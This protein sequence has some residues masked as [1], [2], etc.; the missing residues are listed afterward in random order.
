MHSNYDVSVKSPT[1][2]FQFSIERTD[3]KPDVMLNGLGY[4]LLTSQQEDFKTI[5]LFL[6]QIKLPSNPTEE[7]LKLALKNLPAISDVNINP[8]SKKIHEMGVS[9]LMANTVQNSAV[10]ISPDKSSACQV[11]VTQAES[12]EAV[13]EQVNTAQNSASDA[14]N[15][16]KASV[17]N[18]LLPPIPTPGQPVACKNIE[19]RMTDLGVRGVSIAVI[20]NH[21]VEWAQGYGEL[22][23]NCLIQGGS[24]S[25]TVCALTILSIIDQCRQATEGRTALVDNKTIDLDTDIS[26]LLDEKLWKSIDPDGFTDGDQ[27]KITVRRLLSH[28]AGLNVSGF[29]GYPRL[30][31]IEKEIADLKEQI[32]KPANFSDQSIPLGTLQKKLQKLETAHSKAKDIPI[33]NSTEDIILGRGNSGAVKLTQSISSTPDFK[34][35]GG[36]TT[37]VQHLIEV[38]TGQTYADAVKERVFDKLHMDKSCYMPDEGST[39]HGSDVDGVEIAGHWHKHP[40]LAAAGLWTTPDELAQIAIGIQLS[41]KG[42][43]EG[44]LSR[45]RAEEMLKPEMPLGVFLEQTDNSKYFLHMGGTIGFRCIMIGNTE[46][47][48]AVL[49]TN[50]DR[51]EGLYPEILKSIA[52]TYEWGDRAKLTMLKESPLTPEEIGSIVQGDPIDY[53]KWTEYTG[54]YQFREHIIEISVLDKKITMCL[55]SGEPCDVSPL[56]DGLGAVYPSG[57]TEVV[58]FKTSESGGFNLIYCDAEHAK[59]S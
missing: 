55:D 56:S 59:I 47:Q 51:G 44:V 6:E 13:T 27:P 7:D 28:T 15:K 1:H 26:T 22:E 50:S 34:Y 41:L 53:Q 57:R 58:R 23:Q 32:K 30:E 46:G 29:D 17:E 4:S 5:R 38:L 36:G 14:V 31:V 8:H 39:A 35:S 37:I 48:G 2:D 52:K 19:Q 10:F 3:V 33:P 54:K 25:K 43:S 9:H 12:S 24:T 18:G 11:F 21:K 42:N 20:N 45:E 49:M 16:M 40:E